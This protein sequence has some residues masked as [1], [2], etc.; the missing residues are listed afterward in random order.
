MTPRTPG[1]TLSTELQEQG[2]QSHL[3]WLIVTGILHSH[4]LLG[5]ALSKSL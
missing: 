1:G 5:S 2:E 3:T 4:V